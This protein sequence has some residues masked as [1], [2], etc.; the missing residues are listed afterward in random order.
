MRGTRQWPGALGIPRRRWRK[1]W[2]VGVIGMG[3]LVRGE[4]GE[5]LT[6]EE[7]IA[8]VEEDPKALQAQVDRLFAVWDRPDSPGCAVGIIQNGRLV[9]A[10]GY[11]M[12]NLE[13][14]IPI[15]PRTVFDIASTSKQ[16]TAASLLLLEQQGKLSLDDDVRRFVPELPDYG[17]PITLRHL[18]H[19]TSG[20]RDY[21]TLMALAG[22]RFDGVTTEEDALRLIVRQ[23]GLNFPPGE[24]YL[25]SNSGYFLLSVI[26]K[27]ASGKSLREFAEEHIFRPLG[28]TSTQFQDD[29]TRIVPRRATGYAPVPGG[30]FR[31]NMSQFEQTGDG[32]L[33]TTV[34]DLALWDQNFYHPRVGGLELIRRLLMP[35]QL[36]SGETLRYAAGL[37]VETYRGLTVIRHGGSWA[38]YRA[39]FLRVPEQR[40]SVICLC[41]VSAAD[42]TRLAR[43]VADLYLA[44]VFPEPA[45]AANVALSEEERAARVGIYRNPK[46]R[47]VLRLLSRGATL[48]LEAWGSQWELRPVEKNRFHLVEAPFSAELVFEAGGA[49]VPARLRVLRPGR[50]EEAYERVEPVTLSPERLLEYAGTYESEELEVRYTIAREGNALIV[51]APGIPAYPLLSLGEDDFLSLTGLHYAFRRDSGGRVVGFVLNAGR[52]RGLWFA[53]RASGS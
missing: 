6:G 34:E 13:H 38:G 23:K 25:Y 39:E 5:C 8:P 17:R 48:S 46:T 21:L 40:F 53:R 3:L 41:N 30:G 4:A 45:P 15:T 37:I 22:I 20:L 24:D 11:G 27:R 33:M 44:S 12:A 47:T 16:F 31:I 9:Y 51:R 42:P 50:P 19:H 10:R 32:A 43:Q 35:G 29:H 26:V 28:M 18:L 14:G 36:T 52:A 2:I 1:A 7:R 49:G